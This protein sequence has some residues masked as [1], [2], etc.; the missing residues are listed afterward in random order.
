MLRTKVDSPGDFIQI[1]ENG[2]GL[3]LIDTEGLG[4]NEM[5]DFDPYDGEVVTGI[6]NA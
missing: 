3:G 1:K 4:F 2:G 5:E 6:R